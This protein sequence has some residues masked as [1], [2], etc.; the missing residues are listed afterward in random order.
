LTR[1]IAQKIAYQW[2]RNL[3]KPFWWS[4]AWMIEGIATIYGTDAINEVIFL[5]YF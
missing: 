3:I 2:F 5:S 1:L 4:H